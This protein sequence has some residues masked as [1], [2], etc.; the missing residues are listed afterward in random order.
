MTVS[1]MKLSQFRVRTLMFVIW[2]SALL[3]TGAVDVLK[4][5]KIHNSVE[6]VD[7]RSDVNTGFN[8][9]LPPDPLTRDGRFVEVACWARARREL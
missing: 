2:L 9:L 3:F 4:E 8:T 6:V 5:L 7:K 1:A